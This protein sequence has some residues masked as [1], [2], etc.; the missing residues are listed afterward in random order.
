MLGEA[1]DRVRCESG[2]SE[3]AWYFSSAASALALAIYEGDWLQELSPRTVYRFLRAR[4][5]GA[6]ERELLHGRTI[7]GGW[8]AGRRIREESFSEQLD[9]ASLTAGSLRPVE[10]Q[11]EAWLTLLDKIARLSLPE[12][13][14]L[15][16]WVSG[17]PVEEQARSEG[18][19]PAT[20]RQRLARAFRSLR[21]L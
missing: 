11:V 4:V 19:R 14:V 17:E 3:S 16:R 5:R 12:Q 21:D 18:V 13:D 2:L 20:L 6:V 15:G 7:D 8:H 9:R 10:D 1:V